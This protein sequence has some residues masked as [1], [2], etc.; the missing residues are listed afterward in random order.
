MM[1]NKKFLRKNLKKI[2]FTPKK[3]GV[4]FLVSLIL[5]LVLSSD[6]CWALEKNSFGWAQEIMAT[7]F[8]KIAQL[9]GIIL[10][11]S[12]WFLNLVTSETFYEKILFGDGAIKAI[13]V[14][15]VVV[16]DFL[17]LFFILILLLIAIG[18]ILRVPSYG[19][20]KIVFS[21]VLA[22]LLINFSK[23][24]AL[25]FID[26]SQLAMNF[27]MSALDFDNGKNFSDFILDKIKIHKVL[28]GSSEKQSSD[29]FIGS[30]V[31]SVSAT[32]FFLVMAVMMFVLATSLLV[33]VV[34][35]WILIILSPLAMFGLAMPRTGL[36]SLNRDWMQKMFYWSFFGPVMMFFLWLASLI[37]VQII[38]YNSLKETGLLDNIPTTESEGKKIVFGFFEIIIPY[39][40]AIYM[41]FYGYDASKKVSTGAATSVLNW[42]SQ[43]MKQYGKKMGRWSAYGIGGALALTTPV[44]AAALGAGLAGGAGYYGGRGLFR[45]VKNKIGD[46][47]Q[48]VREKWGKDFPIIQTEDQKKR[49]REQQKAERIAKIKG[50][51]EEK[52]Y[53][54]E[55]ANQQKKEW[56]DS[57][58]EDNFLQDKMNN[59]NEA[60][61]KA[62]A[63]L[64]AERGKIKTGEDFEKALTAISGDKILE[65]KIRKKLKE[66]NIYSFM[67][68]DLNQAITALKNT[69]DDRLNSLLETQ[70]FLRDLLKNSN[71]DIEDSTAV[72]EK[73]KEYKDNETL[74]KQDG[75]DKQLNA[76]TPK[77]IANQ[78]NEL[79]EKEAQI[80]ENF[81]VKHMKF[82]KKD[83]VGT[84]SLAEFQKELDKQ[85]NG[86]KA[87]LVS[88]IVNRARDRKSLGFTETEDVPEP[89]ELG[90]RPNQF[91]RNRG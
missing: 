60:E 7:A 82:S 62:S 77:E 83:T 20:K 21:V 55:R 80:L 59:G 47:V 50:G 24:I 45:E 29:D 52:K 56:E 71:V 72:N 14:G 6:F 57:G 8:W 18:T 27:F 34:A 9:G 53:W 58:V 32:I 75:Y 81:F 26:I 37:L 2:F 76:L 43:K 68:Y 10:G 89:E 38:N 35:Y 15:W 46:T 36:G 39:I 85:G 16:R 12:M 51:E 78:S 44:G 91:I 70:P 19:D 49:K 67:S 64:L 86:Y 11:A 42:G 84:K 73:L 61:K 17:N 13:N 48:G 65:A 63:I 40:V 88:D 87:S 25:V 28:S 54:R 66:E 1:V 22:A 74:L 41:L 4:A 3:S 33:R 79:Y 5:F 90:N 23:P 31:I 69:S 30:I